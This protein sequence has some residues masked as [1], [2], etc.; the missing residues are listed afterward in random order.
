MILRYIRIFRIH[1]Y[2]YLSFHLNHNDIIMTF[3]YIKRYIVS[4][5]CFSNRNLLGRL[6]FRFDRTIDNSRQ[7][8]TD[9]SDF[10][11]KV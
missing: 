5:I 8:V 6:W 9:S 11:S 10:S 4:N 2:R 1:I 7:Q 3:K